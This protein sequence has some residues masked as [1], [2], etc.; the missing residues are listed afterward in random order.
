MFVGGEEDG[1]FA[2]RSPMEAANG[3]CI[4]PWRRN[5]RSVVSR[6]ADR[7]ILRLRMSFCS[8]RFPDKTN[9][10]PVVKRSDTSYGDGCRG[11][12]S[13]QVH[14]SELVAQRESAEPQGRKAARRLRFRLFPG[15]ARQY[16]GGEEIAFFGTVHG[17]KPARTSA[18][19]VRDFARSPPKPMP[20]R[21]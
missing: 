9:A 8:R 12:E 15:S 4:V 3:S 7:K 6:A 16:G 20:R 14:A 13:R 19:R 17:R 21:W 10:D 11:F 2:S 18:R 1:Y 5:G